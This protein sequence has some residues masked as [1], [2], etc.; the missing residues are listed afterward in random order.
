MKK[1]N[2]NKNTKKYLSAFDI[3]YLNSLL[4]QNDKNRIETSIVFPNP[5]LFLSSEYFFES[6]EFLSLVERNILVPIIYPS[7]SPSPKKVDCI[8]SFLPVIYKI[9]VVDINTDNNDLNNFLLP[10]RLNQ[11]TLEI[12]QIARQLIFDDLIGIYVFYLKKYH[13]PLMQ[14]NSFISQLE[15][16]S[17]IFTPGEICWIFYYSITNTVSYLVQTRAAIID[18]PIHLQKRLEMSIRK[19]KNEKNN[20]HFFNPPYGFYH[21]ALLEY[22]LCNFDSYKNYWSEMIAN[23]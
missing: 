11:S 20:I 15:N 5:Q 19:Y 2:A 8:H 7:I 12:K 22:F 17:R 21:S 16:A 13:L 10:L 14:L 9:N 4:S 18:I 3:I 1:C 6:M 23:K